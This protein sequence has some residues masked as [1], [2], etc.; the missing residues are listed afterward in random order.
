MAFSALSQENVKYGSLLKLFPVEHTTGCQLSI[1]V[2]KL[3]T[4]WEGPNLETAS[5]FPGTYWLF[6]SEEKK[7]IDPKTTRKKNTFPRVLILSM[8]NLF[9]S[10]LINLFTWNSSAR[11][12]NWLQGPP[13]AAFLWCLFLLGD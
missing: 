13:L 6:K 11:L 9:L 7:Y 8:S 5:L 4:A 1:E 2:I 3:G 12:Q 10:Y